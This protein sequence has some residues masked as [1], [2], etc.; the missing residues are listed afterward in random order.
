MDA[1]SGTRRSKRVKVAPTPRYVS[2]VEEE[3]WEASL[4]ATT[5]V[6]TMLR[7]L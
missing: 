3:S 5:G 1:A 4:R 6:V 2:V 7:R